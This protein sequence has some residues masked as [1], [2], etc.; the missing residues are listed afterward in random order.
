VKSLL[1]LGLLLTPATLLAHA[2]H[3]TTADLEWDGNQLEVALQ[4][5]AADLLK[6]LEADPAKGD[7]ETAV[8]WLIRKHVLLVDEKGETHAFEWIGLEQSKFGCW[9]YF[10]WVLPGSH[11]DY[12]LHNTLFYQVEPRFSHRMNIKTHS[13]VKTLVFEYGDKGKTLP[14]STIEKP[15]G[16]ALLSP[17]RTP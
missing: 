16:D 2:S 6:A 15:G 8:Q 7:Y 12:Q 1:C 13:G 10:Q 17:K 9:V 5:P 14:V 3:H 4:L 11:E